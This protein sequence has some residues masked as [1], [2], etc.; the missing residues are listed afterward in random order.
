[1][2]L[3]IAAGVLAL[4]SLFAIDRYGDRL[5]KTVFPEYSG[6]V[7]DVQV[8]C[9]PAT[10]AKQG[11][12][13]YK[14]VILEMKYTG[15]DVLTVYATGRNGVHNFRVRNDITKKDPDVSWS[16]AREEYKKYMQ[17]IEKESKK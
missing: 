10:R 2:K 6:R 7:G 13:F 4:A 11:N 12:P 8:S 3:T 16:E 9:R 1:M 15:G 5:D 17:I 14:E